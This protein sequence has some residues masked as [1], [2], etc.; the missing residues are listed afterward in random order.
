MMSQ[1]VPLCADSVR[2]RSRSPWRSGS[3]ADTTA[4]VDQ[5]AD[6]TVDW[7]ED[8]QIIGSGLPAPPSLL[9]E[10][11]LLSLVKENMDEIA[12]FSRDTRAWER[13]LGRGAW[14]A[15]IRYLALSPGSQD[16]GIASASRHMNI[17][18]RSYH[19]EIYR[20]MMNEI[21]FLAREYQDLFPPIVHLLDITP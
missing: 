7:E 13:V 21:V 11:P 10:Q 6:D 9:P 15:I 19:R 20:S 16:N 8:T 17:R 1:Q 4:E 14:A 12:A 18:W 3:V 2:Q 5:S